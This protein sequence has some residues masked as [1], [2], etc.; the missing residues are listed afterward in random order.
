MR[1][2]ALA[3]AAAV[4]LLA[5]PRGPLA[6]QSF[7][8]ADPTIKRIWSIGMDSSHV[9]A[10]AQTLFDSIGPRLTGTP[11][12]KRGNDWLVKTYAS[13]GIDARNE[14][15]GTWR[16]WRRG[17]SHIDLVAPRVRSLEGTMLGYSPGTGGKPLVASTVILPRFADSTAFVKWL[18]S[19]KGKL[20]L[21][22]GAMPTCRPRED[23]VANATPASLAR[24][25]SLRDSVRREWGGRNVRGTGYSLAIGTGELGLRLEQGGVAG[26]VTSRPKD[27]WGSIEIF[28]TYDTRAPAI[29]LSCED[30]GLV[31]RLTERGQGPRL[32]LDLDAELLGERPVFNTIATIRGSEKPDEYVVLSAHFDSWDGS[33]GATDNGTGTLT[34]LEA[35]RILRQAY[36]H[37][38]RTIIAGHWSGEE[39]GEVGSKAFTEDHP[40]VMRGLQALFNQDNGTG[41]V[42]RMSGG[43]LP[44]G[45]E[46]VTRWLSMIP[47]EITSQIKFGGV[48]FP[49][50]GGSDD[51]SFACSGA[52]AFGLGALP[53]DYG[54][55]TWH[56]N[57]DTYDKVVFDDLKS[58]ATLTAMLAYLAADDSTT[59]TRERADLVA[60][61]QAAQAAAATAS[62]PSAGPPR[63]YP[64]TWPACVKAPR[65]TEPR[66]K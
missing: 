4:T 23:W 36:P 9:E 25:D 20:V 46:H 26:I 22:A 66:L 65:K 27:A 15:F 52:P 14:Q 10:L 33:S 40:E 21:V 12:A 28:E 11:D 7:P 43:G 2:L 34:M 39:E 50:G 5:L 1:K 24:M 32:R 19:A 38:K 18:P 57:R 55:Y 48:G 54:N 53:W 64:T 29:A 61:A 58:N 44:S 35:M 49:A 30:Y 13:W 59:I 51:F 63:R 16:G 56:T 8:T 6:A 41:R 37:P 45:A 47:T 31:Y 17:A 42:V 60:L 62:G 3:A